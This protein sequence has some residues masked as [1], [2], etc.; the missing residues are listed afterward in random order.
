MAT[1]LMPL[2]QSPLPVTRRLIRRQ[3]HSSSQL[4]EHARIQRVGLGEFTERLGEVN[5]RRGF[6]RAIRR[7]AMNSA[8]SA[9]CPK[10]PVA[11]STTWRGCC[12]NSQATSR[13]KPV[14]CLANARTSC[15]VNGDVKRGLA[16]VDPD[17]G[18]HGQTPVGFEGSRAL[19]ASPGLINNEQVP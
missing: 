1:P 18:R 17:I 13:R 6:T 15:A 11:S 9:A 19:S 2:G 12:G 5:T 14:D 10:P 4:R 7:P 3:R 8:S 16:D